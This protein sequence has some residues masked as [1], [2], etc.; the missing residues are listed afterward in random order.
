MF[1]TE[2][3]YDEFKIRPAID[4]Q[5]VPSVDSQPENLS[6]GWDIIEFT[7]SYIIIQLIF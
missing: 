3:G 5:I 7:E 1:L 2:D 6:F 4:L